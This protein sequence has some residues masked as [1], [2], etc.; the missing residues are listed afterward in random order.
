MSRRVGHQVFLETTPPDTIRNPVAGAQRDLHVLTELSACKSL[1]EG[2]P[3]L[4]QE[5]LAKVLDDLG[6]TW[7][8]ALSILHRLGLVEHDLTAPNGAR[9]TTLGE[10]MR[11]F[12]EAQSNV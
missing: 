4:D 9:L 12:L 2:H 1:L 11:S 7:G 10:T 5:L 6:N 8:Q 3:E